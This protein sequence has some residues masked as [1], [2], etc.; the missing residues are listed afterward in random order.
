MLHRNA[1]PVVTREGH[2]HPDGVYLIMKRRGVRAW[3]I[4]FEQKRPNVMTTGYH[5]GG[6]GPIGLWNSEHNVWVDSREGSMLFREGEDGTEFT[7][8]KIP[9]PWPGFGREWRIYTD[10]EKWTITIIALAE[11]SPLTTFR[12]FLKIGWSDFK[13]WRKRGA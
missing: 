2:W 13:N 1:L 7:E 3:N 11:F 9:L 10:Q 8:L 5:V 12:R 4:S 6:S